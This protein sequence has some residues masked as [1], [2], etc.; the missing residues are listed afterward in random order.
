MNTVL[1]YLLVLLPVGAVFWIVWRYRRKAGDTE[2]RRLEREAALVEMMKHRPAAP[3]AAAPAA[4]APVA[5]AAP[6]ATVAAASAAATASAAIAPAVS[7]APP[8]P[9]AIA[10]DAAP[11]AGGGATGGERRDRFL[12]HS[13]TLVYF[14]LR[15]GVPGHEVFA[16]ASLASV[17]ADLPPAAWSA[18]GA[19]G[20]KHELDFVVCDRRMRIVAAVQ[21][22]GRLAE[23]ERTRV[24][25]SLAAAGIRLVMLD[26]RALPKRDELGAL[27][28]G[29]TG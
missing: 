17:I 18:T 11:V 3:A 1:G 12:S 6:T 4:A 16:R 14:L 28:L 9:P 2:A 22:E 20:N 10:P 13:E 5:A 7:T 29:A 15:T 24:A 8:D 25:Q 26:L 27:V 21:V 23:P 19:A